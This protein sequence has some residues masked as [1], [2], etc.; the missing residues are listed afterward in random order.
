VT[1]QTDSETGS[2]ERTTGELEREEMEKKQCAPA[3]HNTRR[4]IWIKQAHTEARV[5]LY[6]TS[7]CPQLSD[8]Q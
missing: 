7:V 8:D 1:R 3:R 5:N 2:R 6:T 4:E